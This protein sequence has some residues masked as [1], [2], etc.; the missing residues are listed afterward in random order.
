MLEEEI[1][2]KCAQYLKEHQEEFI[3]KF[4]DLEKHTPQECPHTFF[5]AGAPG[6]G[7]TEVS[8]S[9]IA[10]IDQLKEAVRIDADEVKAWF[11]LYNGKNATAIQGTSVLGLIRLYDH[12]LNHKQH[13]VVDGT[14]SEYRYSK[15]N[16]ER[17]LKHSRPTTI[18]YIYQDPRYAWILTQIRAEIEGRSIPKSYFID[19]YFKSIET[20]N[21]IKKEFG[22]SIS[23][24]FIQKDYDHRIERFYSGIRNIDSY[25]KVKYTK[26]LL[27]EIL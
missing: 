5:M 26:Q 15:E 23:L 16:I 3:Q 2:Q 12:V 20:T 4:A 10:N 8:K 11:P 7:K 9:L 24:D 6:A 27:E 1:K 13:A 19:T 22:N 18:I 14:F 21:A 17:S 25:I